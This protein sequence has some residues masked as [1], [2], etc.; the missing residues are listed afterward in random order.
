M[1]EAGYSLTGLSILPAY[2]E[3]LTKVSELTH[4]L[5]RA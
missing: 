2:I 1:A 5:A 4:A 3:H